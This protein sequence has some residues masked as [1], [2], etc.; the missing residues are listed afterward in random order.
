[1]L[2][3]LRKP[4]GSP[5]SLILNFR[6]LPGWKISMMTVAHWLD[7]HQVEWSSIQE[8]DRDCY[9]HGTDC[10]CWINCRKDRHEPPI[11]HEKASHQVWWTKNDCFLS[12]VIQVWQKLQAIRRL[13]EPKTSFRCQHHKPRHI[14]ELQRECRKLTSTNAEPSRCEREKGFG[15]HLQRE[16][17]GGIWVD[18]VS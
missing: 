5:C 10:N 1:M 12:K 6:V 9:R 18:Q 2:W 3:W 8:V 13:N 11:S 17:S 15:G 4:S 16:L 7:S 14:F